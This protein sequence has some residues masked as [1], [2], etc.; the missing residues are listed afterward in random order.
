MGEPREDGVFDQSHG[1]EGGN[2]HDARIS[3]A[4]A[5]TTAGGGLPRR[6]L[7]TRGQD[8]HAFYHRDAARYRG[9]LLCRRTR[10]KLHATLADLADGRR[11][12]ALHLRLSV[13]VAALFR[14]PFFS[15]CLT[16]LTRF[17][18]IQRERA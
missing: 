7:R 12:R 10:H 17:N 14:H 2:A 13:S 4:R 9:R 3:H 16:S 8:W 18:V 15:P 5:R 11:A 6:P 1:R